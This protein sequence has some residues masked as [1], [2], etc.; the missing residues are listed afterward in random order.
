MGWIITRLQRHLQVIDSKKCKSSGQLTNR[1]NK[2]LIDFEKE[3]FNFKS[4]SLSRVPEYNLS[5]LP[6]SKMTPPIN[7]SAAYQKSPVMAPGVP[8]PKYSSPVSQ[9][10]LM[11]RNPGDQS[12]RF[13]QYP[14]NLQGVPMTG[15]YQYPVNMVPM[16]SVPGYVPLSP[17]QKYYD[18]SNY[19]MMNVNYDMN[20]GSQDAESKRMCI[21]PREMGPTESIGQPPHAATAPTTPIPAEEGLQALLSLKRGLSPMPSAVNGN[22][23]GG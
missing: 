5:R 14:M 2:Y 15:V 21:T 8:A 12:K 1:Y 7:P 9:F 18:M 22:D 20:M 17:G 3:M 6:E 19:P 23:N 10:P 13:M 11:Q 4:P 16:S